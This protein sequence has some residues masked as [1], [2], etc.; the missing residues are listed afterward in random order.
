MTG[1]GGRHIDRW[2]WG[3]VWL[4]ATF[5]TLRLNSHRACARRAP[6]LLANDSLDDR[7]FCLHEPLLDALALDVIPMGCPVD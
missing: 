7:T 2:P 4:I 6:V 5:I 3:E 1:I